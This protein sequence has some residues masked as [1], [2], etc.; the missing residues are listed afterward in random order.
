MLNIIVV[1]NRTPTLSAIEKGCPPFCHHNIWVFTGSQI[2]LEEK[3]VSSIKILRGTLRD[4]NGVMS[5]RE[6]VSS[7]F[8]I[9]VLNRLE[10]GICSLGDN[11]KVYFTRTVN[12]NPIEF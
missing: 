4:Q 3:L 6:G 11:A 9:Q 5:R 2:T 1:D 8:G 10:M 7:N 12:L